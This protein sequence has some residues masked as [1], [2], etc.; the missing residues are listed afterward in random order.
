[1]MA[2]ET[3]SRVGR[4]RGDPVGM[5]FVDLPR[6]GKRAGGKIEIVHGHAEDPNRTLGDVA[7]QV[8]RRQQKVAINRRAD[9]LEFEYSYGRI[10][11][12]AY[13][14]GRT[15]QRVIEAS[16]MGCGGGSMEP[17]TGSSDHDMMISKR[18]DRSRTL[19]IWYKRIR[20]IVGQWQAL[21]ID[22]ALDERILLG[23][24][25]KRIGYRSKWGRAKISRE[26]RDSLELIASEWEKRGEPS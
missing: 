24:I 15:Y 14:A 25:A 16:R 19:V 13:A 6:Q 1:M 18:V 7:G 9:A 23:E 26:F 22:L 12:A 10:S 11:E 4:Y 20:S 3:R 21:I 2:V 5:T 8:G 17:S